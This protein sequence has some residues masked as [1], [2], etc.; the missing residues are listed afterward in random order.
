MFW[1]SSILKENKICCSWPLEHQLVSRSETG[2]HTMFQTKPEDWERESKNSPCKDPVIQFCNVPEKE[3]LTYWPLWLPAYTLKHEIW[4]P[5][6]FNWS[7]NILLFLNSNQS[8]WLTGPLQN[9]SISL[10]L[11][12]VWILHFLLHLLD[13][14]FNLNSLLLS[15][16]HNTRA[17]IN[18]SLDILS[19]PICFTDLFHS[20]SSNTSRIKLCCN[21]LCWNSASFVFDSWVFL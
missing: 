4:S 7:S 14:Q 2:T 11:S 8:I 12:F 15:S 20:I 16:A 18:W 1:L 13:S 5:F 17:C 9:E 19:F 21:F 3:K 10:A 6:S